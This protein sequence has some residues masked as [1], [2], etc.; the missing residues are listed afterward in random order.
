M[1]RLALNRHERA[2]NLFVRATPELFRSQM[3]RRLLTA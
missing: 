1:A 3:V 2:R